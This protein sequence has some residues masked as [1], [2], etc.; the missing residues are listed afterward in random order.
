MARRY[1]AADGNMSFKGR[2]RPSEIDPLYGELYVHRDLSKA[3]IQ[4]DKL[5]SKNCQKCSTYRA[6]GNNLDSAAS[7]EDSKLHHRGLFGSICKHRIPGNFIFM[8]HGGEAYIYFFKLITQAL[9]DESIRTMI[10]KYDI[11]CNFTRYLRV[12]LRLCALLEYLP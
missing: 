9:K 1:I 11:A 4:E 8:T 3:E 7:P 2:G 10:A 5:Y 12:S 6:D